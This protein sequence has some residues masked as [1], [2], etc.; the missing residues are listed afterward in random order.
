MLG[1][2][3]LEDM[4]PAERADFYKQ[5]NEA[6]KTMIAELQKDVDAFKEQIADLLSCKH[7]IKL[8]RGNKLIFN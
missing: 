5:E 4:S 8:F 7:I 3:N 6:L 2:K 1:E